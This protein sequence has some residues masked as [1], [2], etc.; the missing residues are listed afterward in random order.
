MT[1]GDTVQAPPQLAIATLPAVGGETIAVNPLPMP[2]R[3]QNV[4]LN[5]T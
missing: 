1:L 3:M 4:T 5:G 2:P